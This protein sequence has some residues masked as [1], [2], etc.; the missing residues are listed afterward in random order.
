[1]NS[2]FLIARTPC[3]LASN[4][5]FSLA[6]MLKS[7]RPRWTLLAVT[8]P[9]IAIFGVLVA[10]LA[11]TLRG[12][13]REEVLRRE[14]DAIHAVAQLQLGAGSGRLA[15]FGEEFLMDDLFAAV[16]ESSR[17]KGVL[18]VQLFDARGVLRASKPLAPDNAARTRWWADVLAKPEARFVAAA[19][20][21]FVSPVIA[22]KAG[23]FVRVP[24]LDIVVPLRVGD[25]GA[26]PVGVARYWVDGAPV[27]AEFLRMDQR[28]FRQAGLAFLGAAVLVS[29]VLAMAFKRLSEANRQLVEQSTDLTRANQELDFAAKTGALGAI[30]AHLI[31]GL[32]NPLAGIEGFVLDTASGT[33]DATRGEACRTAMETTRRLRSLVS[34]VTAVLH[35]ESGGTADY[36][37]PAREIVDAAKNRALP[38]A[39]SASVE[40][41]ATCDPTLELTAR[42]ANLVGLVL[43]NLVA[44]AIEASPR[45]GVVGIEGRR[46]E[47]GAE[48]LV[49]DSGPGLPPPVHHGLFRPVQSSKRGG[50]GVGLAISHRLAKHAGG[51][52]QL[53]RSDNRGTVFRLV[54]PA[55]N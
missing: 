24:L 34:E 46:Y 35:D 14:G 28:L 53:V 32:K 10:A 29:I 9:T 13:L 26:A 42:T 52:L 36:P 12:E 49:R 47:H 33:P 30:S 50:G 39:G 43:A 6:P 21:T 31:H 22:K 19:P 11:W 16:L 4:D 15:E 20:L 38:M 1:M 7:S 18:A 41:S 51:D 3:S 25:P 44:N 54:V 45:N 37:V 27:E 5:P 55:L 48:F 8:L 23:T 2:S 40:L 17:V